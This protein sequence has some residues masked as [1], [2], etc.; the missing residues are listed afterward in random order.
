MLQA[1]NTGHD[2]SLTTVHANTPRDT[3]VR[4][5]TLTLMSG[6]ELPLK[7]V[8]AQI[9]SAIDL[10]VQQ[11]RL[12]DGSRKVIAITEIQGM[13]MDVITL[14][15]IFVF[16]EE[17]FRD[18]EVIGKM[19]SDRHPAQV[20]HPAG[21]VRIPPPPRDVHGER[22]DLPDGRV[23]GRRGRNTLVARA[24]AR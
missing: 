6:L 24:L 10:I 17:G 3:T 20:Q 7:V 21:G 11:A 2:G 16:K 8:R 9:A 14:S 1:M 12:Q 18:G 22:A 15:D 19:R 13:E 23:R 5:E 4:L